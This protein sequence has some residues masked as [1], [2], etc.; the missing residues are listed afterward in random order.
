MNDRHAIHVVIQ[1]F[2][3]QYLAGHQGAWV[4]SSNLEDARV[5]DF[6]AD[7]IP[8]QLEILKSR[9]GLDLAA[10]P[11]DPRERYE[12][13]DRCGD[14]VMSFR[15]FFDGK[16]YLCPDCRETEPQAEQTR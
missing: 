4:F 5:F 16:E 13:C 10:V 9:H 6:V 12:S 3:G 15:I 7:H 1:N 2:N 14:R 8:E 11:V